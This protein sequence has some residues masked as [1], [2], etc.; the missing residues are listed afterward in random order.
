MEAKPTSNGAKSTAFNFSPSNVEEYEK[1]FKREHDI[2]MGY[3]VPFERNVK[4]KSD[5]SR[6][7]EA[8][9]APSYVQDKLTAIKM[10]NSK[11]PQLDC[12]GPLRFLCPCYKCVTGYDAMVDEFE[13]VQ[14]D[15]EGS[16]SPIPAV[17]PKIDVK[18]GNVAPVPIAPVTGLFVKHY[19]L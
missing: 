3:I 4:M 12:F 13:M 7:V 11:P 15:I 9:P 16:V 2:A 5:W 6:L 14:R 10:K 19:Y 8:F 18:L 17:V 1:A